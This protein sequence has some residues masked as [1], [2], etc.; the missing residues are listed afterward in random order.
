MYNCGMT[1][2]S[3]ARFQFV[4]TSDNVLSASSYS[5]S[6]IGA[7][8]GSASGDT[9]SDNTSTGIEINAARNTDDD[10]TRS[11]FSTIHFGDVAGES[12]HWPGGVCLTHYGKDSVAAFAV[13]G[14]KYKVATALGGLKFSMASGNIENF[15]IQIY[16]MKGTTS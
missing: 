10:D 2:E 6:G 1:A 8:S 16:G 9:S 14:G 4:D 3:Y 7:Q 15:N 12:D 5:N 11:I 13:N